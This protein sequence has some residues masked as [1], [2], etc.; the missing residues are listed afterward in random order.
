MGAYFHGTGP[1][2]AFQVVDSYD[3][4]NTQPT[5]TG[6]YWPI[7]SMKNWPIQFPTRQGPGWTQNTGARDQLQ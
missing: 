1:E 5:E 2:F 3:V 7:A 4:L 6:D